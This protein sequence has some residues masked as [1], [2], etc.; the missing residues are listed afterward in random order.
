ML[1][2]FFLFNYSVLFCDKL[3]VI[4]FSADEMPV[5]SFKK[6]LAVYHMAANDFLFIEHSHTAH[7]FVVPSCMTL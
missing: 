4:C 2:A 7:R 3:D 1:L 6:W 5:H